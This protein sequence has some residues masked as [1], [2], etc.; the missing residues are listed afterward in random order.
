MARIDW[1]SVGADRVV[2]TALLDE[3][4]PGRMAVIAQT[5]ESAAP[6]QPG[7][8]M[9]RRYVICD[10]R[11]R[12]PTFSKADAAQRLDVDL[13]LGEPVPSRLV[14]QPAHV[15]RLLD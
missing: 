13:V 6:K 15:M 11:H 2:V 8:A 9:V 12:D 14:V 3:C 4:L 5:L 7:V 10:P 1:I